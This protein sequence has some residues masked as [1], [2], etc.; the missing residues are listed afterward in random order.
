MRWVEQADLLVAEVS[1]PSLGVGYEIAAA[2]YLHGIRVICLFRPAA[3]P[4]LSS[5]IAGDPE[6]HLIRYETGGLERALDRLT[7]AVSAIA[8]KSQQT[9]VERA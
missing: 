9:A 5:M 2:R 3:V 6:I 4:H 7:E 1:T 8:N